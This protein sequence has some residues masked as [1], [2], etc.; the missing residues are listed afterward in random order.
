MNPPNIHGE[1][2]VHDEVMN[3]HDK[4]VDGK[5]TSF[6]SMSIMAKTTTMDYCLHLHAPLVLMRTSLSCHPKKSVCSNGLMSTLTAEIHGD[7]YS[8]KSPL[9]S[10]GNSS[11]SVTPSI[12]SY[13]VL[14]R[15]RLLQQHTTH[16][17]HHRIAPQ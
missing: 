17:N 15:P 8:K 1:P 10:I 7:P 11:L 13:Q 14:G 5:E 9:P 3:L 12:P 16:N 2:P 4:P 6:S